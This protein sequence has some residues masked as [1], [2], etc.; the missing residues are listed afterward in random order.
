MDW[1]SFMTS[2]ESASS[3]ATS[4]NAKM[5]G[6][7]QQICACSTP[8]AFRSAPSTAAFFPGSTDTKMHAATI[9]L[10]SIADA[11]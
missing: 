5:S 7:P 11:E 9:W 1:I 4:T 10:S 8:G 2:S 6:T 3:S